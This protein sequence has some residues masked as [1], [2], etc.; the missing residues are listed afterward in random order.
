MGARLI[1]GKAIA[2]GLRKDLARQ[3]KELAANGV[4]PGLGVVL[5]GNDAASK[6]Y[7]GN[8]EK[9]CAEIG[10]RSFHY[11]LP[12]TATEK[13]ILAL[14][15]QLNK[16]R[17][18]HGILVQLPLPEG[19]DERRVI[20]S[21]K[22]E[23]DADGFHTLNAGR[24]FTGRKGA[25]PCTPQGVMKLIDS[26]GVE[27]KGARAVI[28]GR[29]N[30]VG[31]PVA[32]LLMERHATVTICHSR[33]KALGEITKQADVLVV[34]VG[35]AGLVDKS[36]VKKGAVV[37]DVGI[38]RLPSG[39][40]AGDCNENV[41]EVAGYYSPVPGGVGPMTV[42]CLLESTVENARRAAHGQA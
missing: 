23:K 6:L 18:V 2:A 22:P 42:A 41:K 27:L 21:V 38:N 24:L 29:S 14:V 11:D 10:I 33:T 40:L 9:A 30:I 28:V 31:K 5:V 26:T 19:V 4:I 34:A 17:N 36:M 39:K 8:K 20:D 16:D 35:K 13:E 3:V 32:M 15:E 37:I 1:D 25:V 7:V 12:G